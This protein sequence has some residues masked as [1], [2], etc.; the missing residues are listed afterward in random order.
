MNDF[1]NI[2]FEITS[3]A[4]HLSLDE[5]LYKLN[6][7]KKHIKKDFIDI[8]LIKEYFSLIFTILNQKSLKYEKFIN[9]AYSVLCYLIKRIYIQDKSKLVFKPELEYLNDC[10]IWLSIKCDTDNNTKK[11]LFCLYSVQKRDVFIKMLCDN[12]DNFINIKNMLRF[13]FETIKDNF[14]IN[15]YA[16]VTAIYEVF[17]NL[18]DSDSKGYVQKWKSDLSI[19]QPV[20]KINLVDDFMLLIKSPELE[21]YTVDSNLFKERQFNST[22]IFNRYMKSNFDQSLFESKESETN[23]KQRLNYLTSLIVNI[24][25]F[26]NEF[27]ITDEIL[28]NVLKCSSSLRTSLT[29]HALKFMSLVFESNKNVIISENIMIKI[30]MQMYLLIQTNKKILFN[31]ENEVFC[32][33]IKYYIKLK[34]NSMKLFKIINALCSDKNILCVTCAVDYLTLIYLCIDEY[35]KSCKNIKRREQLYYDKLS[36]DDIDIYQIFMNDIDLNKVKV[37]IGIHLFKRLLGNS[38]GQVK[39]KLRRNFWEHLSHNIRITYFVEYLDSFEMKKV[40]IGYEHELVGFD[41]LNKLTKA[42]KKVIVDKSDTFINKGDHQALQPVNTIESMNNKRKRNEEDDIY[43]DDLELLDID[44]LPQYEMTMIPFKKKKSIFENEKENFD[45]RVSSGETYVAT[46]TNAEDV[47][48]NSSGIDN[49]N[50]TGFKKFENKCVDFLLGAGMTSDIQMLNDRWSYF[51]GKKDIK[52]SFKLIVLL[53]DLVEHNKHIDA[54]IES[55]F[56]I[57]ENNAANQI[58]TLAEMLLITKLCKKHNIDPSDYIKDKHVYK[59]IVI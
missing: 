23:W 9:I 48:L 33:S 58:D 42:N 26:K 44:I 41:N 2:C 30:M 24:Q 19:N 4:S 3:D 50:S 28:M 43:L 40:S 17:F 20:K 7:F 46:N 49:I 57:L 22:P 6:E 34:Y 27:T 13:V 35:I 8:H 56:K 47:D 16:H 54:F 59:L 37:P 14:E 10:L 29:L 15:E 52:L 11:A 45:S 36:Q 21:N 39:S 31:A 38:S 12:V 55:S 25:K 1:D 18:L 53:N 5:K 51:L 32:K